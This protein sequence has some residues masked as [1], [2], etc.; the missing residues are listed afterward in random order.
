MHVLA[1]EAPSTGR[2]TVG[3]QGDCAMMGNLGR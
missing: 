1:L 3:M 2:V